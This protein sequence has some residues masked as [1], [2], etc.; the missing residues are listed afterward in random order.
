MKGLVIVLFSICLCANSQIARDKKLHL[1]AGVVI[2][3]WGYYTTLNENLQPLYAVGAA[4]IAGAG[5]E[6]VID[7]W[8]KFGT[9]DWRDF[10]CTVAG[11]LIAT[12]T[13]SVIKGIVKNRKHKKGAYQVTI[14]GIS[15]R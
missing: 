10:T 13:I 5:K 2:G 11:G 15:L 12:G 1:S 3:T 6:I 7:K 4:A 9:A 8:L 14:N